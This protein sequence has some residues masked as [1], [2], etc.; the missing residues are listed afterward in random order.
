M[1]KRQ[2]TGRAPALSELDRVEMMEGFAHLAGAARRR[3]YELGLGSGG[4]F[5]GGGTPSTEGIDL[6]TP[7]GAMAF[8]TGGGQSR[9]APRGRC[10]RGE[11]TPE[12]FRAQLEEALRAGRSGQPMVNPFGG[13]WPQSY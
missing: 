7:E 13:S 6:E 9:P 8:L 5:A 3:R 4:T 12:E 2:L 11:E 1:R 10:R